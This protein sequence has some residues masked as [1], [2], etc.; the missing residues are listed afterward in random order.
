MARLSYNF[1]YWPIAAIRFRFVIAN[2]VIDFE[3]L[4]HHFGKLLRL[5]SPEVFAMDS[6]IDLLGFL[7]AELNAAVEDNGWRQ[8]YGLTVATPVLI[9]LESLHTELETDGSEIVLKRVGGSKQEFEDLCEFIRE[10]LDIS[11]C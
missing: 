8:G 5:Q 10:K 3:V 7:E 6:A 11:T 9:Q 2:E 1:W 4:E